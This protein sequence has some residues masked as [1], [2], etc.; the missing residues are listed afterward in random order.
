MPKRL[1]QFEPNVAVGESAWLTCTIYC[2]L[3]PCPD[4]FAA[5]LL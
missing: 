3:T 1:M 5:T 2:M 4:V